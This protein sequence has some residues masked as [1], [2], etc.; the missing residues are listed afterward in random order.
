M[1]LIGPDVAS[2]RPEI[3]GISLADLDG[4]ALD[5]TGFALPSLPPDPGSFKFLNYFSL[6]FAAP[7]PVGSHIVSALGTLQVAPEPVPEPAA[8][9]L[10]GGGLVLFAL[11]RA[12][13]RRKAPR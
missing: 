7:F 10:V 2:G 12:T 4:T 3:V 6:A 13:P 11:R 5:A 8:W 1:E 9:I